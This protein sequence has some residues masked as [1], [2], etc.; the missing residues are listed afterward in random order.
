MDRFWEEVDRV[1]DRIER[2]KPESFDG[3]KAILDTMDA[4]GDVD[5]AFFAGSGGDR[6]LYVSLDVAGWTP[7]W[8]QASYFYAM[9]HPE[10]GEVLTYIEGDVQ[11]G[12]NKPL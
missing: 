12:N 1:L 6:S 4:R 3:V 10:S 8:A 7:A 11:R 9:R 5:S 2:S